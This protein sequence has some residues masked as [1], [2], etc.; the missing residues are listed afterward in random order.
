MKRKYVILISIIIL[1]SF[2]FTTVIIVKE[3]CDGKNKYKDLSINFEN[4]NSYFEE[5]GDFNLVNMKDIDS[6]YIEN[7][8]NI[9]M[10]KINSYTG[11]IP[12]VNVNANMYIIIE[13]KEQEN[14]NE[15][16]EKLETFLVSYKKEWESFLLSEYDLL[17]ESK[18]KVKGKYVY[19]I[20]SE[21]SKKLEDYISKN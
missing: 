13:A 2:V 14:T 15:I 9:P 17:F 3:K 16:Q 5:N 4:L 8:L 18:V 12:I 10:E 7:T 6:S 11:K 1:A 20:I 19:L 21:N